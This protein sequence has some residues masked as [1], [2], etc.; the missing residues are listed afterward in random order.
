MTVEASD[1]AAQEGDRP[2][3]AGSGRAGSDPA[4]LGRDGPGDPPQNASEDAAAPHSMRRRVAAFTNAPAFQTAITA[5]IL[6][7]AAVLGLETFPAIDAAIGPWLRLADRLILTIFCIEISLKFFGSGRAFFRSGWNVFDLI[8]ISISLVP[9]TGAFAVLRA[10][11]VLRVLRLLSIVPE[12]RRVVEALVKSLPG[13]GS[14]IAVMGVV[15]YVGAVVSVTLFGASN[16][17]LFGSLGASMYSL[18]QIMT[19]DGWSDSVVAPVM[20]SHPWAWMF[21]IPFIVVTSFAILNLFIAIIVN[22]M[23]ILEEQERAETLAE[24]RSIAEEEGDL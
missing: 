15:F 3:H 23:Q 1:K 9:T 17:E 19:L 4:G 5:L 2:Q 12:L 24:A 7:N 8:V 14:I 20:Q 13:M 6:A 22:S 18:F 21:F 10:F 11:R 16:P